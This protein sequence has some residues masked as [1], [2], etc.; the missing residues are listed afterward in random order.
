MK[1]Q[2]IDIFSL[3]AG[4]AFL[5]IAITI[6]LGE[7]FNF[8]LNGAVLFPLLLIGLGAL[9]LFTAIRNQRYQSIESDQAAQ[10]GTDLRA[11]PGS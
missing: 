6:L 2:P 10:S 4:L 8:T 5:A 11:A 1:R 7:V 3:G 9:G